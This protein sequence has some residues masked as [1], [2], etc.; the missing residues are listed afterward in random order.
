MEQAQQYDCHH[1][2]DC[3]SR[4]STNSN[5]PDVVVVRPESDAC[6]M[7]S[8]RDDVTA[9]SSSNTSSADD[10]VVVVAVTSSS[11]TVENGSTVRGRKRVRLAEHHEVVA[12]VEEMNET[13]RDNTWWRQ[14]DFDGTKA[15]V[16]HMCRELRQERRF[17]DSLTDAYERACGMNLMEGGGDSG[18][19]NNQ[20]SSPVAVDSVAASS[21]SCASFSASTTASIAVATSSTQ[22]DTEKCSADLLAHQQDEWNTAACDSSTNQGCNFQKSIEGLRNDPVSVDYVSAIVIGSCD[23]KKSALRSIRMVSPLRFNFTFSHVMMLIFPS[24]TSSIRCHF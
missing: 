4:I 2:L 12:L 16:K 18:L 7:V 3:S 8:E 1:S 19:L 24:Q 21:S 14:E 11:T 17:S 5:N 9:S 15:L 10:D 20:S 23:G 6:E 22:A 13:E